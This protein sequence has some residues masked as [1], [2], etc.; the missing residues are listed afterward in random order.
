MIKRVL[1]IALGIFLVA[2]LAQPDRSVPAI[3][4]AQDML[5]VTGAPAEI[6]QLVIG[7]CYDC[8]SDK[9]DYP[10][11]AYIT[12]VN[13]WVQHHINEGREKVNFS[14]WGQFAGNHDAGESGETV[15]EG[16]MPPNNYE[17]MHG[18]AQLTAAQKETLV[19]WFDANI[20]GG[21][22][23]SSHKEKERH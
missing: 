21:K 18:H 6:Q 12:P 2:Q 7:A 17:V 3:D 10:V 20:R 9:V 22:K 19:A 4:P 5:T 14:R 1:L 16:E 8:H 13:F 23:S 11:W 15:A